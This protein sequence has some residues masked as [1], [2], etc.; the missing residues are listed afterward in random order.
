MPA[1]FATTHLLTAP[2]VVGRLEK[3]SSVAESTSRV[4]PV[5]VLALGVICTGYAFLLYYRLIQRIGHACAAQQDDQRQQADPVV[6][7]A[8]SLR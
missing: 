2:A 7:A 1:R 6:Q 5:M 3:C 8:S 4:S